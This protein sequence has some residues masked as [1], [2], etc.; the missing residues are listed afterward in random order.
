MDLVNII[1]YLATLVSAG[2]IAPQALK[3]W[4]SKKTRDISLGM[5]IIACLGAVLWLVYGILIKAF[6]V[7]TANSII[8]ILGLIMVILKLKYK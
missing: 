7:I 6:P 5:Y 2:S 8:F 3:I 4:K 1:G